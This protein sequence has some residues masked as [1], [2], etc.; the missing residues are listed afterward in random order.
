MN[1]SAIM[2]LCCVYDINWKFSQIL[3]ELS[4]KII[5]SN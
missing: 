5:L 4:L 3:F 1:V 2:D